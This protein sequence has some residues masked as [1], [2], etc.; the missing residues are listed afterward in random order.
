MNVDLEQDI[1][2]GGS[3]LTAIASGRGSAI[4]FVHGALGDLRQWQAIGVALRPRHRIIALSR[5][6]HWPNTLQTADVAYSV[7]S[8]RD[9]LLALL[10]SLGAPVHLVGHSYGAL[11]VLSAALAAVPL[12][13]LV[14]IEPPLHGL[15]VATAPGLH[16][17][18]ASRGAMVAAMR[19][20]LRGGDDDAACVTLFD[21]VQAE[22]GGFAA[23]P[24][25][26]RAQL[27]ANARTLGPTY[28][29]AP[30]AIDCAQLRRLAVPALVLRGARTR[31]FYRLAAESAA[32]CIPGARCDVI[33]DA[34]HMAIVENPAATAQAI[35]TFVAAVDSS[36]T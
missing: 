7:E 19:A 8:H 34:A 5:R 28:A 16:D 12:K 33:A 24:P 18:L 35:D 2:P 11:V 26:I 27:L 23:L 9:D 25:E 15:L 21:W 30:P 36:R 13:S 22:A 20:Q 4:V 14:L 1:A 29:T 32:R 10:R 6:H 17:E 31:P 3:G